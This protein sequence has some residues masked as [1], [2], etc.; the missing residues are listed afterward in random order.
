MHVVHHVK[1]Q[2]F[3]LVV[4]TFLIISPLHAAD[5]SQ[6][7]GKA[8][9]QQQIALL[10]AQVEKLQQQL[11]ALTVH[12]NTKSYETSE[13]SYKTRFYTGTYEALYYVNAE[14]LTK[15]SGGE[16]R[17][18]DQLLWNTFVDIAGTSFVT[19]HI[20]EFRIYNDI[21]S[22][23]SAFVEEKPDRTW[24]IGFNREGK[25]IALIHDSEAI[26]D[27]LLHEYAHIV[28]FEEK[29]IDA[30]FAKKFWKN[31]SSKAYSTERFVSEYAATNKDEDLVESFV[32]F[33]TDDKPTEKGLKYDKIRFFYN[34][35]E[36]IELRSELRASKHI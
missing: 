9:L 33:V 27:L 28:F 14:T 1:R 16:V 24:I 36:L 19:A 12:K 30:D 2:I 23:V 6:N 13:F 8:A 22:K 29:N 5:A 3:T 18:A 25:D 20:S 32:V 4:A 10:T 34:Y 26:I 17:H 31:S 11:E 35:P 21:H 7:A 15:Q